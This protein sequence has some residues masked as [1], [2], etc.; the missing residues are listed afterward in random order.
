MRGEYL[1][2]DSSDFT[3]WELPPHARRIHSWAVCCVSAS[4]T[5]SACAE[6]TPCRIAHNLNPGNYLRM[7][8]EYILDMTCGARLMELPPHAR[9]IPP[10]EAWKN[11][12]PGTT[13]ACAENTLCNEAYRNDSRNYLR[14]RGEYPS[15]SP[16]WKR[17]A[18]LP[19]HARRILMIVL[20]KALYVGT[21]SACAENTWG[22]P[23]GGCIVWNYLRMRGEYYSG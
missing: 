15:W 14:M 12:P 10:C 4:G 20:V 21:T 23:M 9:R 2:R 11:S 22:S 3:P 7:R 13:S 18:E 17:L 5:T 6:N 8:G 1:S 19:P 16:D